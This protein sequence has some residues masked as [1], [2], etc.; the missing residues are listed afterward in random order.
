MRKRFG[1]GGLEIRIIKAMAVK[2]RA[3]FDRGE[4][5][6]VC[7]N[8]LAKL[9][10]PEGTETSSLCQECGELVEI[11]QTDVPRQ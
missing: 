4:L 3:Y 1:G 9:T 2:A 7:P 5:T 6:F 8:C 10:L 11:D